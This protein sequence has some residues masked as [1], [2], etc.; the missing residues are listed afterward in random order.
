[1]TKRQ[2]TIVISGLLLAMLSIGC[3][4]P[5][6]S[7][8]IS[9]AAK[10]SEG[11]ASELTAAEIAALVEIANA[12]V[13]DLNLEVSSAQAAAISDFLNTRDLN[14]Q[15]DFAN[16]IAD[17]ANNPNGLDIDE[18]LVAVFVQEFEP[19]I[20]DELSDQGGGSL[21]SGL[22]K[23]LNSQLQMLTAD[24]IQILGESLDELDV[25]GAGQSESLSN[26]QAEAIRVF[27]DVND[28]DSISEFEDL[29]PGQ[30]QI[31]D[32]AEELFAGL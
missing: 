18:A 31:P 27:L 11:R 1:M 9:G 17:A 29:D 26:E 20:T 32:G 8:A 4:P 6:I 30:A 24:E 13:P 25:N 21:T 3:I 10:L 12:A 2:A 28:I 23:V 22:T 16:L 15:E 14:T 19:E 7:A 5:T